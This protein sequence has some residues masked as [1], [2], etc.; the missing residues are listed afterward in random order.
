MTRVWKNNK[1]SS[2]GN[3]QSEFLIL[4]SISNNNSHSIEDSDLDNDNDLKNDIILDE[5][6]DTDLRK[7]ER[8]ENQYELSNV[9][10]FIKNKLHNNR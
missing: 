10:I 5:V 3:N 4:N 9:K 6:N 1:I 8:L 2:V 7:I